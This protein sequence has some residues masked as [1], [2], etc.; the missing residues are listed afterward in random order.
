MGPLG[1][2][3]G[4]VLGSAVS[5][6]VVLGMILVIY[7]M[8]AVDH[9]YVLEEYSGLVHALV[10]FSILTAVAAAAFLGL[11]RRTGWRWVAQGGMWLACLAIGLYYWP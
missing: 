4:V 11:Q 6:A 7:L 9:P 3:T 8:I 5:I 2:L 10:L 1:F